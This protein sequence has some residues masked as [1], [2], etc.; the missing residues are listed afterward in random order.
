MRR[1]LA[2]V[3]GLAIAS[4]SLAGTVRDDR[5]DS[6][7]LNLGSLY[8]SVGQILG[9]DP[10]SSFAASAVLVSPNW[11]LTAAHVTSGATS[12][13]YNIG[14]NSYAGSGWVTNPN[15][16]GSLSNGYDLGL[17][18]F[19]S[20]ISN[21]APALRY[22][23][24]S[25]RGQTA[26]YVGYGTTGTGLTGWKNVSSFSQLQKRGE[27]NVIDYLP[28][29]RLLESDFDNPV[30]KY[31][32]RDNSMGS[33]TPLDLEG[34]IAPGDSGGG[35][36]INVGGVDYLAGINS[37]LAAWD[38]RVNADYGDISG[39]I[40]VSAFNSWIDSVINGPAPTN[41]AISLVADAN[42]VELTT[43]SA[44]P[45]PATS[46]LFL[47]AALAGLIRRRR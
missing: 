37:F 41:L 44:V 26:T 11:A 20:A 31:Q 17:I 1:V 15:W 27:Q 2:C 35:V 46:V 6:L 38:G 39:A 36:F 3:I 16:T 28:N 12:L 40:R 42:A 23:G 21:V 30:K 5:S 34:L 14:G 9:A 13:S 47:V 19:D 24:S 7:Y 10:T 22:T 8:P 4:S 43:G 32:K 29:S 18:H 45:E 33:S 25:E